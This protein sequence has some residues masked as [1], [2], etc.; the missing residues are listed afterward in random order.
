MQKLPIKL[1]QL[2]KNPPFS[3]PEGYFDEFPERIMERIE[4]REARVVEPEWS[5]RKTLLASAASILVL[6]MVWFAYP[7]QQ[8]S[9]GVEPF[10]EISKQSIEYY[11]QEESPFQVDLSDE[12]LSKDVKFEDQ[13]VQDIFLEGIS[14]RA[15]WKETEELE[16]GS[17][18]DELI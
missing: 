16:E 17:L 2:D 12:S 14:D 9:I 5:M 10:Q 13:V 15:L 8:K 7:R 3:V 1:D 4:N 11:L 18:S 6:M